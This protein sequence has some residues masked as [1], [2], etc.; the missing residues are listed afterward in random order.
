MSF[1][2][3][4]S[5]SVYD[6]RQSLALLTVSQYQ[7]LRTKFPKLRLP[8]TQSEISHWFDP[9]EILID[10]ADFEYLDNLGV[11]MSLRRV[12]GLHHP[13]IVQRH[14]PLEQRI[15]QVSVSNVGLMQIN[16]VEVLED[17]CTFALQERLNDGWKI[18]AVC[19]PN[20]TRRP[21]YIVGKHIPPQKEEKDAEK[22]KE[23][24]LFA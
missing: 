17:F 5:V 8:E 10:D 21:T 22:E 19:P 12:K 15:N 20:D 3:K 23:D 1:V 16:R 14:H 9:Y 24:A 6:S 11:K 4:V 13:Q 7:E 2:A 18:I